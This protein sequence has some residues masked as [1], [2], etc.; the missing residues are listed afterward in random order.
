MRKFVAVA[1]VGATLALTATAAFAHG[2]LPYGSDNEP[3]VSQTGTQDQG[4]VAGTDDQY[5]GPYFQ[6]RFDNMGH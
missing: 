1:V 5:H 2:G 3:G 6:Q 4:T